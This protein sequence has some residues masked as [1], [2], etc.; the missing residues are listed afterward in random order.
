M[1]AL[2]E[3]GG[4][5]REV[6]VNTFSLVKSAMEPWLKTA[7]IRSTKFNGLGYSVGICLAGM[8]DEHLGDVRDCAMKASGGDESAQLNIALATMLL[9][10]G[11]GLATTAEELKQRSTLF[12]IA[13]QAEFGRRRGEIDFVPLKLSL[14]SLSY[15]GLELVE[16]DGRKILRKAP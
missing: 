5:S 12:F 6:W 7:A 8:S 9:A 11:E 4:S 3:H 14:E 13:V 10:Q 2:I 1:T 15:A 16:D